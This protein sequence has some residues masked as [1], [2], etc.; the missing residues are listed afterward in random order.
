MDVFSCVFGRVVLILAFLGAGV[1]TLMH[2]HPIFGAWCLVG[3]L[4]CNDFQFKKNKDGKTEITKE[5]ENGDE[6]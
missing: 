2:G 5:E 6:D 3:A 4:F 1:Y